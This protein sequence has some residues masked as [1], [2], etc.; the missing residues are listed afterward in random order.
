M[1]AALKSYCIRYA[2]WEGIGAYY[3]EW[4]QN[5]V[6][7]DLIE[8]EYRFVYWTRDGQRDVQLTETVDIF[9][10]NEH[11][12]IGLIDVFDLEQH[13]VILDQHHI[14]LREY[15]VE[16]FIFDTQGCVV[17]EWFE[18]HVELGI[19]HN[20]GLGYRFYDDRGEI[21]MSPRCVFLHN[22]RNDLWYLEPEEFRMYYYGRRY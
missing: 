6:M 16:Y 2:V 3:P 22:D 19:V 4:F 20:D 15:T 11:G 5:W 21:A 18:E 12:E 8:D 7:D 10:L 14:C 17:P 9:I 13:Y 1:L